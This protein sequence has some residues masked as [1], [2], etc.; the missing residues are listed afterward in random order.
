MISPSVKLKA[1]VI[2]QLLVLCVPVRAHDPVI[3]DPN[4]DP[5][6]DEPLPTN[7]V[8]TFTLSSEDKKQQAELITAR[9]AVSFDFVDDPEHSLRFKGQLKADDGN[10]VTLAYNAMLITMVTTP[11]QT[12]QAAT[13]S[14]EGA[15]ILEFDKPMT[16]LKSARQ[17]LAIS[18]RPALPTAS[19]SGGSTAARP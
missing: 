7:Y 18:I 12:R 16:I 2:W 19:P 10:K 9:R 4:A 5:K 1:F 8:I 15:V 6:A 14:G 17:Q 3:A 13:T 11:N